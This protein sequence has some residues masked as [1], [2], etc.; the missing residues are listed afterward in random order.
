MTA[1]LVLIGAAA[2]FAAGMIHGATITGAA[3]TRRRPPRPVWPIAL[4]LA[5]V[6]LAI[7]ATAAGFGA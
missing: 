2:L 5:L 1:L 6:G 3:A 7:T 4:A